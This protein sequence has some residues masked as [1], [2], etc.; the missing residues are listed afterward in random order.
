MRAQ[1]DKAD[2]TNK[3]AGAGATQLPQCFREASKA[4]EAWKE[5]QGKASKAMRFLG[6]LPGVAKGVC[7]EIQRM[8]AATLSVLGAFDWQCHLALAKFLPFASI[9][10]VFDS[11]HMP[12]RCRTPSD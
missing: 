4:Y 12:C 11:S 1:C 6:L 5:K 2:R 9:C 10:A 7:G 8:R 3:V